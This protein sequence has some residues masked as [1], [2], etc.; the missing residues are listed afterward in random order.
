VRFAYDP[1]A[2]RVAKEVR[3]PRG[4]LAHSTVSRTRFVW[5][6][7]VLAHE[8]REEASASGDPVVAE[9]TYLYEDDSFEPVAHQQDGRW[10]HYLN[11]QIGTPER[12]LDDAGAVAC[13][14]RR[15]AWGETEVAPGAR[16]STP[17]RFQGQYEDEETGLSYNRWRYY[18]KRLALFV[19]P[20]PMGLD[21]ETNLWRFVFSPLGWTDPLGLASQA[22][23]CTL[24][25]AERVALQRERR[26]KRREAKSR[27]QIGQKPSGEG[28][29]AK[30]KAAELA[31]QKK[32]KQ[33][34]RERQRQQQA[35]ANQIANRSGRQRS[36]GHP[37]AEEH[38]R[39]APGTGGTGQKK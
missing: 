19:A 32:A 12:L 31:R 4:A 38:S 33:L 37:D 3:E 24:T 23:G 7:D 26:R 17:I 36:V 5:D 13:E 25:D 6:G 10:V 8:I 11:D 21:E 9:R 2:R 29:R 20:D 16:A 1:F 18:D 14:L 39:V 34:A 27:A 35:A 15:S 22:R 30:A 28:R